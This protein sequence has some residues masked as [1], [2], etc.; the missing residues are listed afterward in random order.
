[1]DVPLD[2]RLR[3]VG[4]TWRQVD[5]LS[6]EVITLAR[7]LR[8]PLLIHCL[9]VIHCRRRL[10]SET[11]AFLVFLCSRNSRPL[12]VLIA[13][14]CAPTSYPVRA[15]LIPSRI[16]KLWIKPWTQTPDLELPQSTPTPLV[17]QALTLWTC[18]VDPHRGPKCCGKNQ[19]GIFR[20]GVFGIIFFVCFVCFRWHCD[21]FP[22][23]SLRRLLV[24]TNPFLK[25]FPKY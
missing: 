2:G 24:H 6:C 19:K 20:K 1:M 9:C 8:N 15:P 14:T 22:L 18:A 12:L 16:S 4:H 25:V 13:T 10:F 17:H 21:L 3:I 23:M 11:N 7:V 5:V